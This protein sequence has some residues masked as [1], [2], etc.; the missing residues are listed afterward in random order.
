MLIKALG[1]DA[2]G[3]VTEID[4]VDA[5]QIS[6][7][8]NAGISISNNII[9]AKVDNSTTQFIGWQHCG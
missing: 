4:L 1:F 6:G 5:G 2:S 3:N 8:T 7:D 9:S